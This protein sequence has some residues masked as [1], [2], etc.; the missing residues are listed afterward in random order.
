MAIKYREAEELRLTTRK[1]LASSKENWQQF[2]TTASNTYKYSFSE[3]TLIFAQFPKAKAVASFNVWSEKF[4][5]RIRYNE[6]GIGLI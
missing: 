2:L 6:K 4:G 3:Q 1:N 5:R